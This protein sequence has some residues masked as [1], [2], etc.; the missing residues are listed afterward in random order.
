MRHPSAYPDMTNPR[1]VR[2][3]M[4]T[5][6]DRYV[7]GE[8]RFP[9]ARVRNPDTGPRKSRGIARALHEAWQAIE[10]DDNYFQGAVMAMV[11]T[12]SR[13]DRLKTGKVITRVGLNAVRFALIE[14]PG[15]GEAGRIL[16]GT[17]DREEFIEEVE[18]ELPRMTDGR[19]IGSYVGGD[20]Q[21]DSEPDAVVT[22][23]GARAAMFVAGDVDELTVLNRLMAY[24]H[25]RQMPGR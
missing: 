6:Y 16:H 13:G 17:Q 4:H 5:A 15:K 9:R 8:D 22:R 25:Q 10:G 20:L 23:D 1:E 24:E 18:G 19:H 12:L 2:S 11:D 14:M 3:Y 7:H 21:F